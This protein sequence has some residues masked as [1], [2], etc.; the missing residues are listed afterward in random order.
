MY[1]TIKEIYEN[2][3][4]F[5]KDEKY[6][7][8]K[9]FV[10]SYRTSKGSDGEKIAFTN[11]SDGSCF[12]EI[13]VITEKPEKKLDYMCSVEIHGYLQE[14]P[15]DKKE[16]EVKS[17]FVKVVGE[18]DPKTWQLPRK[19]L[20]MDYLRT[21]PHL[22]M[23]TKTFQAIYRIRHCMWLEILKFLDKK[24]F[25]S[26]HTPLITKN[27]C[28]GAGET[29]TV[30]AS[31]PFFDTSRYLTVSGQIEGE[32]AATAL[33][34]IYTCGP[35]FRAEHSNTSRHLAEFWMIEPEM[36]W[37]NV[38]MTLELIKELLRTVIQKCKKK[39][40]YELEFLKAP[41]FTSEE[42]QIHT[43]TYTRAIEILHENAEKFDTVPI[44]GED[45][46]SRY[47]QFLTEHLGGIVITT[48]YPK[49]IKSF[50]MLVND[51]D[52]TVSCF[53]VLVPGIGEIIGGSAREI[54]LEKLTEQMKARKISE[55]EF[56]EYLD[57]RKFGSVPHAGFGLGFDRFVQYMTGVKN[58]KDVAVFPIYYNS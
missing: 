44:W 51:D 23:R 16:F 12:K 47:E 21:I 48:D 35:T 5:L 22:R 25:I 30:S 50:Y 11:I 17:T 36:S 40:H 9:G 7:I 39:C 8:I 45:L 57:I 56:K 38:P 3:E 29:F 58:I 6:I 53:D 52:R 27:D 1:L 37:Y 49:A 34:K 24:G 19:E 4:Q 31:T 26:V 33:G 14:K 41:L 10:R 55:T 2:F 15:T 13:Q 28:E 43:I 42:P 54:R 18:C 46:S 32:I 20:T